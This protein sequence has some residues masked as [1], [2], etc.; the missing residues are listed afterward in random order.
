M[1]SA[2]RRPIIEIELRAR[3]T[4]SPLTV[5]DT[6]WAF[7]GRGSAAAASQAHACLFRAVRSAAYSARGAQATAGCRW[8]ARSNQA[9]NRRR[10]PDL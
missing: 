2:R 7:L 4:A 3:A 10:R 1:R 9:V 8:S 5:N 6:A